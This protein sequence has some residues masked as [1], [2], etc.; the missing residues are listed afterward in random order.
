MTAAPAGLQAY[1]KIKK[2]HQLKRCD[3]QS[4][5]QVPDSALPLRRLRDKLEKGCISSVE[6]SVLHVLESQTA[7]QAQAAARA[8]AAINRAAQ[9]DYEPL[10]VAQTEAR[11]KSRARAVEV[12]AAKARTLYTPEGPQTEGQE[13]N[14]PDAAPRNFKRQR[15]NKALSSQEYWDCYFHRNQRNSRVS[16]PEPAP[17]TC[18]DDDEEEDQ[19]DQDPLSSGAEG[20]DSDSDCIDL[21][22]DDNSDKAEEGCAGQQHQQHPQSFYKQPV[23]IVTV[24]S[25]FQQLVKFVKQLP[26][27]VNEDKAAAHLTT[28]ESR[29][30]LTKSDLASAAR[31][32]W[33]AVHPDK[34][35]AP[36]AK[37]ATVALGNLLN[38]LK[39]KGA[40]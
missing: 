7:A 17:Q 25:A 20:S 5:T 30:V 31:R 12:A 13:A 19:Y 22:S 27:Q 35:C 18:G 21:D 39:E 10:T 32:I 11:F 4:H 28:F 8:K 26:P 23:C 36:A 9:A 40:L 2:Q 6:R 37:E 14:D 1:R 34:N 24:A 3:Q 33:L 29:K 16:K 15:T 38:S